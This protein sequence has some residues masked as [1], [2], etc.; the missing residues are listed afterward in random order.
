MHTLTTAAITHHTFVRLKFYHTNAV[1]RQKISGTSCTFE[2]LYMFYLL[3]IADLRS[4]MPLI[5]EDWLIDLLID[6][7]HLYDRRSR[8]DLIEAY[9]II[10]DKNKVKIEVFFEFSDTGYNLREHCYKLAT[11][12]THLE[13]RRNF[14][15]Q[16]VVCAWNLLPAH[17][18]E[19]P[20]VNA[21][22]NRYDLWKSGAP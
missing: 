14:F 3:C 13:V 19:T 9:K 7:W 16:H 17:I 8:E 22:K 11:K 20:P 10:T 4:V 15:S 2:L 1:Q 5:N 6:W 18:V 21:F 12:R